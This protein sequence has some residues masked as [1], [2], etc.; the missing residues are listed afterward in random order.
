MGCRFSF[1]ELR[2]KMSP[3][4]RSR[5]EAKA[6]QLREAMDLRK[7][8]G[9]WSYRRSNSRRNFAWNKPRARIHKTV[10]WGCPS[11]EDHSIANRDFAFAVDRAIHAE[12][13]MISAH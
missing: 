1:A 5:A 12:T 2:G 13:V 4:A 10:G 9:P 11:V 3:K 7:C 8:A 6:R